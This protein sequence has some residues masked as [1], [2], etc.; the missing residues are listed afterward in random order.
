[1]P[2]FC[3]GHWVLLLVLIAQLLA[4]VLTLAPHSLHPHSFW[5]SLGLISLFVQWVTLVTALVLCVLRPWLGKLALVWQSLIAWFLIQASTAICSVPAYQLIQ[6][7]SANMSASL[8]SVHHFL[9]H[10]LLISAI[11]GAVALRYFYVQ[12]NWKLQLQAE[13]QA[14][15][16]ALQARI[17]PHFLFNALNTI[18]SLIRTRP[19]TAEVAVLDLADIFRATLHERVWSTLAEELELVRRYLHTEELRLGARLHVQWHIDQGIAHNTALPALLLQPLVENAVYHGIEPCAHGGTITIRLVRHAHHLIIEINN[20][21]LE[22]DERTHQNA[23]S[24]Q[25]LAL[26]NIR[27]RLA[28][29]YARNAHLNTQAGEGEQVYQVRLHLP[30]TPTAPKG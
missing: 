22:T 11:I 7:H 20:P 5:V 14:R 30:L 2:N 10:N 24:G 18:A 12:Q 28:L 4:F 21:R 6:P 9:L 23:G 16:Q 29:L 1:M 17:R 15:I 8:H 26:E 13:S 19:E 27:Q 25:Q 3:Q